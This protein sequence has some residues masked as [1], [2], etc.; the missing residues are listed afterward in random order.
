[1][2]EYTNEMFSNIITAALYFGCG[3]IF[4]WCYKEFFGGSGGNDED[5]E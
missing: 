5:E 1:M 2:T 3:L 4:Y